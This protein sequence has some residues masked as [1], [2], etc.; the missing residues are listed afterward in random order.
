MENVTTVVLKMKDG[1][2]VLISGV[3]TIVDERETVDTILTGWAVPAMEATAN[4]LKDAVVVGAADGP[5]LERFE[6]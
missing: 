1:Q 3:A 2:L 6:I 4:D 5:N